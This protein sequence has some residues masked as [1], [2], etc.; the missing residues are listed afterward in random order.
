MLLSN[1]SHTVLYLIG[2]IDLFAVSMLLPLIVTHGLELGASPLANG[3]IGSLYGGI[4]LF[5]SPVCGLCSDMYGRSRVLTLSLLLCCLGYSVLTFSSTLTMFIVARILAGAFKHTQTLCRTMVVDTSSPNDRQVAIGWFNS[6][7][8]MAFIVGPPVG[9]YLAQMP[10]GYQ[11]VTTITASMFA[12][13]FALSALFVRDVECAPSSVCDSRPVARTSKLSDVEWRP[14][15]PLLLV[16]LLFS[17]SVLVVRANAAPLWARQYG[18]TPVS[19]GWLTSVQ[20]VVGSA[21]G[22]A[23]GAVSARF[24]SAQLELASLA[25]L[26]SVSLLATAVVQHVWLLTAAL[27]A[28]SACTAFLRACGTAMT[29]HRCGAGHRGLVSGVGQNVAA[30]ARMAAPL[31]AGAAQQWLGD[32][33]STWLSFVISLM[34]SAAATSIWFS[35]RSTPKSKTN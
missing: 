13:M 28:L 25:V 4:Q 21:A 19:F 27:C 20:S 31:L 33:G 3:V 23:T 11:L 17:L 34:A 15:A 2:F 18:L 26:M 16:R 8:S 35:Y 24:G 29:L 6:V 1:H 5:S 10:G 9:G 22:L 32:G 14:L 12:L 30:I 7:S